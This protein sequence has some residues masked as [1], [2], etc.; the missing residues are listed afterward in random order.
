MMK[1]FEIFDTQEKK[2]IPAL[3]F[4]NK[5]IA[6]NKRRELNQKGEDGSEILR[7]VVKPGPQHRNYK[8]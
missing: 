3:Y 8:P 4:E 2:S 7:Y 6:K 5:Q 1:L